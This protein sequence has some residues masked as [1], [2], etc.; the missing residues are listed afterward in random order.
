MKRPHKS[1]RSA[2]KAPTQRQLRAG[3][4]VRHALVEIFREEEINDP[5]LA[6]IPVGRMAAPEEI[7]ELA[8]FL[9]RPS[10]VSVNG[11]VL[12]VN[13]GSYLR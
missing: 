6:G 9:F 8:A 11:A 10:Q 13:G 3:E 2:P 7:G 12:D 5:A 1:V 4:L